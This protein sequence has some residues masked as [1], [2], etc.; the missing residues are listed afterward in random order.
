MRLPCCFF[1]QARNARKL[2]AMV[3]AMIASVITRWQLPSWLDG[4]SSD[5][6][7]ARWLGI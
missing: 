6:L 4:A 2:L 7:Q 3:A 5:L 1:S